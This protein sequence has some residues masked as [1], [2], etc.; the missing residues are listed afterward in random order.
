M[1]DKPKKSATGKKVREFFTLLFK[2]KK[3]AATGLIILIFFV[4][5]AIFADVIAPSKLVGGQISKDIIHKLQPP[6]SEHLLG[7]D[8]LGRDVFSYIVYGARTSVVLALFCTIISTVIGA[9]LGTVSAVVGG[10]FDLLLQ[11][12]IDAWQC[13]P[14]LLIT[15]LLMTILGSGLWQL[16]IVISIPG[17]IANTR[18][19][20]S[21]A[22]S[23][24][25]SG[26]VKMSNMLGAR[27]GWKMFK[28]FIPNT[29]PIIIM[30]LANS[31][32]GV[33][34]LEA[35]L[36]FLGFGVDPNTPSWGGMLTKAG[37]EYMFVAPWLAFAP[38]IAITLMV[39]A[40]AMFGDG[41]RDILDPRLKGGA[42]S[43]STEK[44]A[45][46]RREVLLKK[47]ADMTA[48]ELESIESL[49]VE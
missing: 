6:S 26:Y 43:F 38:G 18:L 9:L 31:I 2:T 7:T 10:K 44:I 47:A 40:S 29:M 39:L 23:V 4:L 37:T 25:D 27:T 1:S 48:E 49:R 3:I 41:V 22:M 36:S 15:L 5:L 46:V 33:V 11:R 21:T 42:G 16:I 8:N 13:I 14:N 20:R 19:Y 24:K 12:F 45:K 32:G 35:G 34:M 17:G 30:N 28:H